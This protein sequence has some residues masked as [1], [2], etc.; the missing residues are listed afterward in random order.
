V[1]PSF[2]EGC[3]R[4]GVHN[5]NLSEVLNKI[6]KGVGGM[7]VSAIVEYTFVGDEFLST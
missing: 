5:T 4:Y 7:L 3:W 2:D 6:L 1:G